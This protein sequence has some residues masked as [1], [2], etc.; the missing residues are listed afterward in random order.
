M[1]FSPEVMPEVQR[2]IQSALWC[3]LSLIF[4]TVAIKLNDQNT[5]MVIVSQDVKKDKTTVLKDLSFQMMFTMFSSLMVSLANL[6][7]GSQNK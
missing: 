6:K 5:S 1:N 4:F 7:P 2:E 3:R